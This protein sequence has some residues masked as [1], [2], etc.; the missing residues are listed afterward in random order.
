LV[1]VYTDPTAGNITVGTP[2]VNF[3]VGFDTSSSDLFLPGIECDSTCSGHK[4]YDP[5]R[6]STSKPV[7]KPFSLDFGNDGTA[8][9]AQFTD[10]IEIAGLTATDQTFGVATQYGDGFNSSN[11]P[12]DGLLGE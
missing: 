2:P 9:G 3:T 6:S 4:K 12:A 5:S 8:S 1:R 7:G 11:F 10:T